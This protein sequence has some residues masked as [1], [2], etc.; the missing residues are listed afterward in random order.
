MD[1]FSRLD[2]SN[3]ETGMAILLWSTAAYEVS[4]I[5]RE[6]QMMDRAGALGQCSFADPIIGVPQCHEGVASPSGEITAVGRLSHAVGSRCMAV[7][8]A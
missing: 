5:E 4:A 8:C 3:V 7:Q 6:G 2:V 1:M